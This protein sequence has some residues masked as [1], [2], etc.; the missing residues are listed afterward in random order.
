MSDTR[1]VIEVDH[2]STRFGQAVVHEDHPAGQT[3]SHQ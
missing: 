2:V 3:S 1:A